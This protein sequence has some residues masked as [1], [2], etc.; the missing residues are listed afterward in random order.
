MEEITSTFPIINNRYQILNTVSSGGMAV[1]YRAR[2][3]SLDRV[4]ALKILK[5]E[6]SK[7]EDFR[8]QFS[9]EA[10]ATA[11]LSHVNIVATYDFGLY[12]DRLYIAMEFI[13]GSILKD[14]ITNEQINFDK[15]IDYIKQACLG[16]AFAHQNKIVHCDIKPQNM[17]VSNDNL[18]KLT[19]FGIAHMLDTISRENQK[20]EIWGS[21]FYI[22]PEIARGDPPTPQSDVY[23][24]G[25]V[26]YELLTGQLPF[27][28]DEVL[29]LIEKHQD[30]TPTAP[31]NI[32]SEIPPEINAIILKALQKQP[33]NRFLDAT[34]LLNA[35]QNVN[36]EPIIKDQAATDGQESPRLFVDEIQNVEM[37]K[38]EPGLL[39]WRTIILGFI[40][41]ILVGGLI[42]F[43][44]FIYYSINR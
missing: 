43:W 30:E 11:R 7:E 6:L 1:I 22:A 37:K 5:K 16:L 33:K 24:M 17:L 13:E 25:I 4:I 21:P 40:A 12:G 20:E 8:E 28:G 41:I 9:I 3:L 42:P 18:L 32:N 34:E 14:L 36:I 27:S 23:S 31:I 39:E 35:I 19:D 29:T 26:M 15:R 44:L 2:D 38:V 10:K